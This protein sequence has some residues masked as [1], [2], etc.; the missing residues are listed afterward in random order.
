MQLLYSNP[1]ERY[2]NFCQNEWKSKLGARQGKFAWNQSTG[3]EA[4]WNAILDS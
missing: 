1:E 4:L 3:E 2:G